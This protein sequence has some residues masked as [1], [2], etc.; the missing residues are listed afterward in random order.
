VRCSSRIALSRLFNSALVVSLADP[1][2]VEIE[3]IVTDQREEPTGE[4][5]PPCSS[6]LAHR[7]R[8]IYGASGPLRRL[9]GE[10][11]IILS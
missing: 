5:A 1:G 2:E 9:V 10:H 6:D 3:Q 4:F 7:S 11:G 8:E